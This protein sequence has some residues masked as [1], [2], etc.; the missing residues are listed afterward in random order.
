MESGS[1]L[2][3]LGS[4]DQQ[5]N[6][7]L[8]SFQFKSVL[9]LPNAHPA[10]WPAWNYTIDGMSKRQVFAL[11]IGLAIGALAGYFFGYDIGFEDAIPK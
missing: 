2:F 11:L 6:S 5:T 4:F 9:R 3:S 8:I 10:S 7:L 1:S